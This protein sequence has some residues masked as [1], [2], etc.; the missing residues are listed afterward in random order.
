M[1]MLKILLI[2]FMADSHLWRK[3][4]YHDLT[5]N[6]NGL[7]LD[8]NIAF[9]P[10]Q[11]VMLKISPKGKVEFLDIAFVPKDPEIRPREEQRMYF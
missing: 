5:F 6:I 10:Y 7:M 11:S 4:S 2:L 1:A 9:D 8:L 3:S